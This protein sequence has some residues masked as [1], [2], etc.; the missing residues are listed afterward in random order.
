MKRP[1]Y[2]EAINAARELI[3]ALPGDTE[4]SEYARGVCEILG[5]IFNVDGYG[6]IEQKFTVAHDIGLTTEKVV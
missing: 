4:H 6:L 3:D 5:D 1:T 2:D